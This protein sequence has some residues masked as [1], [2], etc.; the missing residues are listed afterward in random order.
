MLTKPL[1]ILIIP[2]LL[3][4]GLFGIFGIN[5]T[6]YNGQHS[7]PVSALSSDNCSSSDGPLAEIFHHV[8]VLQN[9]AQSV[10]GTNAPFLTLSVILIIVLWFFRLT[11]PKEPLAKI[12]SHKR[13]YR[14]K[15]ELRQPKQR[16]LRWLVLCEKRDPHALRWVHDYS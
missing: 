15:A 8:S 4:V 13:Y 5:M 9:F 16:L 1:T 6:N 10:V 12:F 14:D 7:C 3:A 2:S 11:A